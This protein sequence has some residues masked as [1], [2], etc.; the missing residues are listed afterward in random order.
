M[1][2]PICYLT[3][4]TRRVNFP[5]WDDLNLGHRYNKVHGEA[6]IYVYKDAIYLVMCMA[7]LHSTTLPNLSV[8]WRDD[9]RNAMPFWRS[10]HAWK[11]APLLRLFFPR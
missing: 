7:H 6:G 8:P 10:T 5:R 3:H 11:T 1:Q 9:P 2:D 4:R